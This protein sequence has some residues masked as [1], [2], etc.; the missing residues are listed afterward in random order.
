MTVKERVQLNDFYK[1]FVVWKVES[2]KQHTVFN[3]FMRQDKEWK[4]KLESQIKPILDE[5]HDQFVIMENRSKIFHA[6][7]GVIAVL[8]SIGLFVHYVLQPLLDWFAH[9]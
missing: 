1:C 8:S 2:Q 5:R 3:N 9:H 6:V 7:L 4:S